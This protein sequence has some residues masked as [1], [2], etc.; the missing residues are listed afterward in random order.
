[1]SIPEQAI[2]SRTMYQYKGTLP[3]PEVAFVGNKV[4]KW[5]NEKSI[6]DEEKSIRR[7]LSGTFKQP[8]KPLIRITLGNNGLNISELNILVGTLQTGFDTSDSERRRS[9]TSYETQ[10]TLPYRYKVFSGPELAVQ[11]EFVTQ[12]GAMLLAQPPKRFHAIRTKFKF[13]QAPSEVISNPEKLRQRSESYLQ[14]KIEHTGEILELLTDSKTSKVLLV[15]DIKGQLAVLAEAHQDEFNPRWAITN[16]IRAVG[17]QESEV[18]GL[19]DFALATLHDELLRDPQIDRISAYV[20]RDNVRSH[21][22][23]YARFENLEKRGYKVNTYD[24]KPIT[25]ES[26]SVIP[27][28]DFKSSPHWREY[29]LEKT[30]VVA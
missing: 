21:T 19:T 8:V 23:T 24:G 30:S 1:M 20:H 25:D 10:K 26:G 9:F 22:K 16:V 4:L 12:I 6:W 2:E 5:G 13:T 17:T 18:T 15:Y 14:S 27:A 11:P 7:D 29:R 28:P 3:L